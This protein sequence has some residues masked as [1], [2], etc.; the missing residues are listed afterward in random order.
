[1]RQ[2][3]L[4]AAIAFAIFACLFFSTS[5][6]AQTPTA[7]PTAT[8]RPADV[9]EGVIKVSSRLVVVPVS[10]TDSNGQPVQGL[11]INDFR[12]AEEGRAQ[13]IEN[14]GTADAVPLDIALLFDV[15]ASTDAMFRFQQQTAAQFLRDV[16]RPADRAT[17]YTIG[18]KAALIQGRDTAERSIESV[19]TITPTK[20]AT[21]F[22]DS[23]REAANYLRTNSPEG[24]RRVIVVISDGE[25]NFSVGVQR[26]G[27]LT[28]TN[29]T[30]A[31]GDTDFKKLGS[32]IVAAQQK[33]K[34]A[35]RQ[36]VARA[37]QDADTVFYSINPAG[38]SYKLNQISLFGQENMQIFADQTGG[39]A[40]IPRFA[41][42]D[43]RDEYANSSNAKRNQAAL[44]LIFRQLANE[45][46]AQYLVQY[47]SESEYPQGRFVKLD[48]G[49]QNSAGRRIRARQ[50]Y[51]A[52]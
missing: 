38:S 44:E 10:I 14:V 22:F 23:V 41:P 43:T 28:E 37:L 25:D 35:E 47:Y 45:L 8:P 4:A 15:S 21:A 9:D 48:V 16:M 26:A 46:R 7:T 42:I 3:N 31:K 52:K 6:V 19:T 11:T 13:K 27:R 18:Q 50:G 33:A 36:K 2:R 1:M 17:I 24:R 12:I 30:T 39:S 32:L 20:G 29:I 40:F 49:L 51:Y 5:L 34:G